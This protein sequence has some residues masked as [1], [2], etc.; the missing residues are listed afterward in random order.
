MWEWST[1]RSVGSSVVLCCSILLPNWCSWLCTALTLNWF[2]L[3]WRTSLSLKTWHKSW[4]FYLSE[5][6]H[7]DFLQKSNQSMRTG[8]STL[9]CDE[10]V[11]SRSWGSQRDPA[12]L[13]Q[14]GGRVPGAARGGEGTTDQGRQEKESPWVQNVWTSEK[15][16]E[17]GRSENWWGEFWILVMFSM[18]SKYISFNIQVNRDRLYFFYLLVCVSMQHSSEYGFPLG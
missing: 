1:L 16:V 7:E 12:L 8:L 14:G 10:G 3:S 9:P 5:L 15:G 18:V 11:G 2:L 6:L 13:R 17:T 4:D